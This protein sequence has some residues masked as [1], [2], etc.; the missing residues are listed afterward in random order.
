MIITYN[1]YYIIIIFPHNMAT[2]AS[3]L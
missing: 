1:Y 3:W 2:T